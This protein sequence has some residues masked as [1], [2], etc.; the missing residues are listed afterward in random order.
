MKVPVHR[1]LRDFL[2]P[3]LIKNSV[4]QTPRFGHSRSRSRGL[5]LASYA[6]HPCVKYLLY[7]GTYT[8]YIHLLYNYPR[9]TYLGIIE[10]FGLPS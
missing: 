9:G 6:S 8:P 3:I 5:S 4:S 1:K 10:M 7:G 2:K